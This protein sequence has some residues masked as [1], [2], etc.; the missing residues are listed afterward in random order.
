[1]SDENE[2]AKSG[3]LLTREAILNA[4]EAPKNCVLPSGVTVRVNY[5]AFFLVREIHENI[6]A[7]NGDKKERLFAEKVV[8]WMLRDNERQDLSSFAE[9]DQTRLIE[10][11]AEEWG[12]K[13][14]YDKLADLELPEQRFFRAVCEQEEEIV[15]QLSEN[16]KHLTNGLAASFSPV[17]TWQEEI[18]SS[19][20]VLSAQFDIAAKVG[21]AFRNINSRVIDQISEIGA[22]SI[23]ISDLIGSIG[24]IRNSLTFPYESMLLTGVS[25][26]IS[27]YQSL[28]KDVLPF[29]KFAVLPDA[30]RY[31]PTIEM[32]NT[33][34]VV[35]QLLMGDDYEVEEEV[36]A[37]V[38]ADGLS[39]WLET[40]DPSFPAM[41][42]GASQAIYSPNPDRCRHFASSH[43]ELCTHM[44]HSLAPDDAVKGWTNNPN[45]FHQG[46]PTRKARLLYIVRNYRNASFVDFFIQD[47]SNQMDLLN[48]DEHRKSQEYTESQLLLLH[49]RF[50][51]ALQF[52]MEIVRR[53]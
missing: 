47:F 39:T 18:A 23:P 24:A 29:E 45:H 48:A 14:K 3:K 4:K 26:T 1:M 33:S 53:R 13:E 30:I 19:L 9:E 50:L 32:H 8:R 44:L 22:L 38:D 31:Y 27:S 11:A 7:S 37:P 15:R 41:L 25:G 28:M 10:I 40:L 43:R 51:S 16:L 35:G 2:P 20:K 49:G 34:I 52:L 36:I 21:D 12:C 6:N 17:L 42:E 46:R 5:L